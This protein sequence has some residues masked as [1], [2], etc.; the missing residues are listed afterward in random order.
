MAYKGAHDVNYFLQTHWLFWEWWFKIIFFFTYKTK[1][2]TLS[3]F[4]TLLQNLFTNYW[5]QFPI[6][7][8]TNQQSFLIHRH[9]YLCL[10][11]YCQNI[12]MQKPLPASLPSR[13]DHPL[14]MI[15]R[16]WLANVRWMLNSMYALVLEPF[17]I[18]VTF[19]IYCELQVSQLLNFIWTTESYTCSNPTFWRTESCWLFT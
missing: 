10:F 19:I 12:L 1:H 11:V 13:S 5:L 2:N 6:F 17:Y 18:R 15:Y 9:L 3:I 8:A 16:C 14:L 7:T 4:V